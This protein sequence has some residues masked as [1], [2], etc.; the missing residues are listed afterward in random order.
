MAHASP[1][2]YSNKSAIRPYTLHSGVYLPFHT[3][4]SPRGVTTATQRIA[5]PFGG[6]VAKAKCAIFGPV[7]VSRVWI[8]RF[9]AGET[10][11]STNGCNRLSCENR[12]SSFLCDAASRTELAATVETRPLGLWSLTLVINPTPSNRQLELLRERSNYLDGCKWS[13]D[14]GMADLEVAW[15]SRQPHSDS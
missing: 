14:S 15:Q 9:C 12:L 10:P 6:S 7:L 8:A 13:S 4:H 5:L 1:R 11:S 2:R 3:E